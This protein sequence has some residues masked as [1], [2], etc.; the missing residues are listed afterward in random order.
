MRN[1]RELMLFRQGRGC[2]DHLFAIRQVL[3]DRANEKHVFWML[4]D[5]ENVYDMIN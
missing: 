1:M 5:L 3:W 2:M 4:M